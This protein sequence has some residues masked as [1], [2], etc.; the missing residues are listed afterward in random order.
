MRTVDDA[1]YENR[2]R[3]FD[4]DIVVGSVGRIP[5]AGQRAARLLGLAVGGSARLAQSHRHQE[6]APVDKLIDRVVFAK[7]REELVAA[8]KALDRVLLWNHYVVPQ[9]TYG[10]VRTARWD[11]FS[12]P[13]KLPEYGD[14]GLPDRLVVGRGEGRQDRRPTVTRNGDGLTRRKV[15]VLSAGAATA[16]AVAPRCRPMPPGAETAE[17]VEVHGISG[18]GDL[19][20]PRDFRHFDYVDPKAPEG[21]RVLA[22]RPEPAVQPELPHLQFA[23]QLHPARATPRRAWS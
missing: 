19:K 10:K 8:T 20:Y 18:F 13:E 2:A 4:F 21:R 9:W 17:D 11:R 3:A 16:G 14:V 23:Q 7:S 6:P 22:D 12:H 15:L 5:V 1:Q